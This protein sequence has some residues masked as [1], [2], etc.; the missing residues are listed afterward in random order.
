MSGPVTISSSSLLLSKNYDLNVQNLSITKQKSTNLFYNSPLN[1]TNFNDAQ[2][3]D[4]KIYGAYN[5]AINSID[6][7]YLPSP[8]S[9]YNYIQLHLPVGSNMTINLFKG[10]RAEFFISED[11]NQQPIKVSE[12]KIEFKRIKS[13]LLSDVTTSIP[14][15]MKTPKITVNKKASFQAVRSHYPDNPTKPWADLWPL[16]AKGKTTIKFD[17]ANNDANNTRRYITYFKWIKVNTD[18]NKPK[19]PHGELLEIPWQEIINS[20]T[21]I[22]IM[23]SILVIAIVSIYLRWSPSKAKKWETNR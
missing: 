19:E 18:T 20:N 17:H 12:G 22:K 4:L 9:P 7:L 8:S 23:V 6:L 16:E 11:N 14:V 2:V 3:R 13:G 15:L 10:S 21:N 5:V 1:Q